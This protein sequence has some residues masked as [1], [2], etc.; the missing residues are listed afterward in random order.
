[1]RSGQGMK[2]RAPERTPSPCFSLADSWWLG[3]APEPCAL[4]TALLALTLLA[5]LLAATAL[6]TAL[7]AATALATALSAAFLAATHLV[8]ALHVLAFPL[9]L[10]LLSFR[11]RYPGPLQ[12]KRQTPGWLRGKHPAWR[13]AQDPRLIAPPTVDR[14]RGAAAGSW[15]PDALRG[16]VRNLP[17]GIAIGLRFIGRLLRVG[18]G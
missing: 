16:A 15:S 7:L 14:R 6:G 17:V 18:S 5:A 4:G 8:A 9:H 3:A 13:F 2:A 11:S 12:G 10:D 1:M